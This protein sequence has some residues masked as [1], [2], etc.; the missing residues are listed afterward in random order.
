MRES[1]TEERRA[2]EKVADRL[3]KK[4]KIKKD[5]KKEGGRGGGGGGDR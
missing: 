2:I 5:V 3:T 1:Q 4:N